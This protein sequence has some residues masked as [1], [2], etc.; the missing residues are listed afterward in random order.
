MIWLISPRTANSKENSRYTLAPYILQDE[1]LVKS[2]EWQFTREKTE[3]A[4]LRTTRGTAGSKA[5]KLAAQH[6]CAACLQSC[7]VHPWRLRSPE[8]IDAPG[9]ISSFDPKNKRMRRT[10]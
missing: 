4:A 9:N 5:T 1:Q 7:T 8:K 3:R 6:S 2:R 10:K